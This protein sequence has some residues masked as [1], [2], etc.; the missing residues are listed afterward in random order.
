M[1]DREWLEDKTCGTA[2]REE[3]TSYYVALF[4]TN[5]PDDK[6]AC[7]ALDTPQYEKPGCRLRPTHRLQR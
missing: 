6:G 3:R 7:V 1:Q 2:H 4:G 5:E